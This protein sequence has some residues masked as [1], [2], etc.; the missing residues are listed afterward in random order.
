MQT[1]RIKSFE[2]IHICDNSIERKKAIRN[3][4]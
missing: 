1:Y 2:K 3:S 4:S